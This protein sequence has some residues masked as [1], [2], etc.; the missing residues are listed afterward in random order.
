[1][2]MSRVASKILLVALALP[3]ADLLSAA[4]PPQDRVVLKS[5]RELVGRFGGE[6]DHKVYFVD[7]EVGAAVVPRLHVRT[8]VPGDAEPGLFAPVVLEASG[9]EPPKSFVRFD[10]PA[11]GKPGA[12]MTGIARLFDEKTR[13][14]V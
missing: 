13:T 6:R 4:A 2:P 12:L 5:G 8:I 11:G 7:E 10:A 9:E 14:T 3:A 1:M